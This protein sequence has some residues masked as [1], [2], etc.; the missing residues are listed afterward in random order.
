M[1]ESYICDKMLFVISR[2]KTASLNSVR[3]VFSLGCMT[4]CT[5][6][7]THDSLA[8]LFI[9]FDPP[10]L[11]SHFD[12]SKTVKLSDVRKP[13]NHWKI[14]NKKKERKAEGLVLV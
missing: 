2:L 10:V 12:L 8:K 1:G 9:N 7:E 5:I 11:Y 14:N 4:K 3:P 6:S 13:D